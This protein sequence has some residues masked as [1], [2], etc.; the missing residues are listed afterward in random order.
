MSKIDNNKNDEENPHN[1][2]LA[3]KSDNKN[4]KLSL[5]E[6]KGLKW[7]T[8]SFSNKALILWD[9]DQGRW[10]KSRFNIWIDNI[11]NI[12]LN[13]F[14]IK[15]F[16]HFGALNC[17]VPGRNGWR[18]LF[19]KFNNNLN[20]NDWKVLTK[21]FKIEVLKCN[22]Q[23]VDKRLFEFSEKIMNRKDKP[24][25]I[26]IISHDHDMIKILKFAHVKKIKSMIVRWRSIS[27]NCKIKKITTYS[28][29]V[30][31]ENCDEI[32]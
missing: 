28:L 20:N 17:N 12:I 32:I 1:L 13:K 3:V 4:Y 10:N 21:N 14:R 31:K 19:S 6:Y 9:L 22:K 26:V 29:K 30:K 23:A 27:K 24:K 18:N 25:L 11:E 7:S 8:E 2:T 16:C 15:Q 5:M